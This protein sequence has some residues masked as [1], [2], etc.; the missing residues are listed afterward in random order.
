MQTAHNKRKKENA[1]QHLSK[2]L[3]E[4]A[5]RIK[6]DVHENASTSPVPPA[7]GF[8]MYGLRNDDGAPL[9]DTTLARLGIAARDMVATK[10]YAML[11]EIC[12]KRHLTARLE[13]HYHS[14]QPV[15]TKTFKLV[16]DGWS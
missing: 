9:T 13:E 10:G 11:A 1:L 14:Q 3:E 6:R 12:R 15:F 7:I 4:I 2:Q 8:V 16:V 5:Q